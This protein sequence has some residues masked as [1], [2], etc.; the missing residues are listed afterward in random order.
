MLTNYRFIINYYGFIS[1]FRQ[2]QNLPVSSALICLQFTSRV[3]GLV[4][5]LNVY[6][7]RYFALQC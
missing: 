5:A 6:E 2:V 1:T 3:F 7:Y 4:L